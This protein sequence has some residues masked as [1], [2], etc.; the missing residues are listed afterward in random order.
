MADNDNN[1]TIT[2]AD[3]EVATVAEVALRLKRLSGAQVLRVSAEI[4]GVH[5]GIIL[6]SQ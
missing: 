5:T 4:L 6:R 1:R 2:P 3:T